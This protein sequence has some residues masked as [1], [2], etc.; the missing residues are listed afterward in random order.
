[1]SNHYAPVKE[2]DKVP[3]ASAID[4]TPEDIEKCGLSLLAEI[5]VARD[6]SW[7]GE[8]LHEKSMS[9]VSLKYGDC[10]T[11]TEQS[12][13][14]KE[15]SNSHTTKQPSGTLINTPTVLIKKAGVSA[16]HI[17]SSSLA[18][19][20]S[21][22][23]RAFNFSPPSVD[24]IPPHESA[25]L[26][27]APQSVSFPHPLQAQATRTS[28]NASLLNQLGSVRPLSSLTRVPHISQAPSPPS[29]TLQTSLLGQLELASLARNVAGLPHVPQAPTV[30]STHTSM[31]EQLAAAQANQS[32]YLTHTQSTSDLITSYLLHRLSAS[33][34][35][36][37]PPIAPQDQ[38]Q[39]IQSLIQD[40]MI[41]DQI[42]A[43]LLSQQQ[44]CIPDNNSTASDNNLELFLRSIAADPAS[45]PERTYQ[46]ASPISASDYRLH[47]CGG[48]ITNSDPERPCAE[49]TV[50]DPAAS[51][52]LHAQRWMTRYEELK[53]FQQRQDFYPLCLS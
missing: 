17:T 32:S 28:L 53:Q 21:L 34:N 47:Y 16:N 4:D 30:T 45:N 41:K 37:F 50:S 19:T 25:V 18:S 27:A 40:N 13:D 35:P 10:G 42:I 7:V 31:L 46:G 5:A 20:A 23:G 3:Q 1:M 38:S 49:A 44:S 48:A 15:G 26:P 51:G 14:R 39:L 2:E 36:S 43:L 11:A 9:G 6:E 24:V 12:L 8:T 33:Q 52:S 29:S 22:L